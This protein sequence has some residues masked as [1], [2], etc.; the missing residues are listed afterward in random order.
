MTTY[1]ASDRELNVVYKALAYRMD[2]ARRLDLKLQQ[3]AWLN[4][5]KITC[6]ASP[7]DNP[8]EAP[9]EALLRCWTRQNTERTEELRKILPDAH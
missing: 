4:M 1:L 9:S 7:D 6:G 2:G 5:R 3:R 8:A